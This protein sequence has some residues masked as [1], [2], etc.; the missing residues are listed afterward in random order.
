MLQHVITSI[1]LTDGFAG[2]LFQRF[3]QITPF[4]S[5]KRVHSPCHCDIFSAQQTWICIPRISCTHT[6]TIGI[7]RYVSL[8][9]RSLMPQQKETG[10]TTTMRG[11]R[12]WWWKS[13]ERRRE[14]RERERTRE[15]N[16][17]NFIVGDL[18]SESH[19][20]TTVPH[21]RYNYAGVVAQQKCIELSLSFSLFI[22][23]LLSISLPFCFCTFSS[24]FS[25][26]FLFPRS[27]F[28]R[29]SRQSF[30]SH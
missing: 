30:A 3:Q 16:N 10:R 14:E 25:I 28:A 23:I 8:V 11:R 5:H 29:V 6:W 12:W 4:F 27:L 26:S 1:H 15:A 9:E 22:S 21:A 2:L 19:Y 7:R 20:Q 24:L 18:H 17:P 13:R